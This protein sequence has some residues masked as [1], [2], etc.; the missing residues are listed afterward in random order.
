MK[1]QIKFLYQII[2]FH[3]VDKRLTN[4]CIN[5]KIKYPDK[6]TLIKKLCNLN[7]FK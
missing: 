1:M 3:V 4:Y 7:H 2:S 6:N 5:Y